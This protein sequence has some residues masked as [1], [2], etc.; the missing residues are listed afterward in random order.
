MTTSTAGRDDELIPGLVLPAGWA[1]ELRKHLARIENAQTTVDC[2]LA[3]ERVTGVII[4][5]EL[6]KAR[7]P[8]TIEQL[9][10]LAAGVGQARLN[11]L[12]DE[13]S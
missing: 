11:Q 7:D 9:Y 10:L 13:A 12:K 8:E 4:G 1:C 6:A 5:L 2:S 3:L